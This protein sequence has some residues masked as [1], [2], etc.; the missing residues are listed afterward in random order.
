MVSK[1]FTLSASDFFEGNRGML[2]AGF[3]ALFA[4]A[5]YAAYVFE[6]LSIVRP[7]LVFVLINGEPPP[8]CGFCVL[9]G[10]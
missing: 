6:Q 1:G 2:F 4:L 3:A 7:L 5:L 10:R 9:F 8:V